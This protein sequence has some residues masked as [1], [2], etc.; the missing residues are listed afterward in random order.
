MHPGPQV[1]SLSLL[2][3]KKKDNDELIELVKIA[4]VSEKNNRDEKRKNLW[5]I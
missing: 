3:P 1:R 2:T 4:T 5:F